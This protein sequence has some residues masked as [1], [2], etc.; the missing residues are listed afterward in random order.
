[1]EPNISIVLLC[2]R[3][4]ED[5]RDFVDRL[6]NSLELFEKNWEIVLVGN[7][8][9]NTKDPTPDVVK[10]IASNQ[11]RIKAV[12]LEKSGT[13]GWDM[14]SG[15]NVTS[16]KN[17]A[18]IDGDGQMPLEDVARVYKSLIESNY[19]MVKTYR[20]DRKDGFYRFK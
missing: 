12:V 11:P 2:Y 17:I 19:D 15:L 3:S 7:Y 4:G 1:M 9:P 10:E 20:V 16:G 13:M 18:V 8:F 14:R 6:R 5:V